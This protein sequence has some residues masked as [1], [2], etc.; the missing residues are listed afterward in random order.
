MPV[1]ILPMRI[2]MRSLSWLR[3]LTAR[4]LLCCGLLV[5]AFALV[6]A[7]LLGA[8]RDLDS[9]SH[10]ATHSMTVLAQSGKTQNSISDMAGAALDYVE[11]GNEA[12]RPRFDVARAQMLRNTAVLESLVRDNPTQHRSAVTLA[13]GAQG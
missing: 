9:K 3:G 5:I 8:F 7:L 10:W 12:A 13:A 6:F 1:G 11:Q 2:V 4:M